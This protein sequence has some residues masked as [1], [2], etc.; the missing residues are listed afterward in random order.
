MFSIMTQ[1][2]RR[3]WQNFV[4]KNWRGAHSKN[5]HPKNFTPKKMFTKKMFT[6]QIFTQTNFRKIFFFTESVRLSFVDLRWA[7]LYVSLVYNNK[8]SRAWWLLNVRSKQRSA[9]KNNRS[10]TF[11]HL[12]QESS[13]PQRFM[14]IC[15]GFLGCTRPIVK[16]S[17]PTTISSPSRL[18]SFHSFLSSVTPS[19]PPSSPH[20]HCLTN[21][22]DKDSISWTFPN[23][24]FWFPLFFLFLRTLR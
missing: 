18:I 16:V 6:Q 24:W 2:R 1:N 9:V 12:Y 19:S 23:N 5:V 17:V 11:G 4:K 3:G 13:T 10:F 21:F 7:Q 8:D 14:F 20:P 22:Q 15:L